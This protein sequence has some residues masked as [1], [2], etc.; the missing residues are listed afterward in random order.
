MF[1]TIAAI[2]FAFAMTS[3]CL[4]SSLE[5]EFEIK[6]LEKNAA[7]F[8]QKFFISGEKIAMQTRSG[9][10]NGTAIFRGDK[11]L[12]WIIDNQN[13]QYT[14]MTKESMAQMGKTLNSV[15]DQ[16]KA[17]MANMPPEQRAMMENLMKGQMSQMQGTTEKTDPLSF[18]KTGVRKTINGYPCEK[19][20]V[21]RGTEKL[22]EMWV[23]EWKNMND[24]KEAMT[25]FDSMGKFFATMMESLKGSP[26]LNT[27]DIPY[28]HT[29][30]LN[31]FPVM[32]TELKN[33]VPVMEATLKQV[34]KKPIPESDFNPP[35]GYKINTSLTN[36][37][38]PK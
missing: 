8:T 36:L 34:T 20:D 29:T 2:S 15:M 32:S 22:R 27:M 37:S 5:A 21:F 18:K 9:E 11:G 24:F 31:G 6:N 35:A 19:Y 3:L 25:A 14:E 13:K 7:P 33:G 38:K 1:K 28:S 10:N 30:E 4:A 17:Q 12:L 23:T 26:F 16:M